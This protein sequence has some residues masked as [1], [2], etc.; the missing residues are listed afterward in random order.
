MKIKNIL[1]G[2]MLIGSIPKNVQ[3][4]QAQNNA[5]THIL[6]QNALLGTFKDKDWY[7]ENI[8]FLE[9]PDNNIQE[10]YYYRWSTYKLHLRYINAE[11]GYTVTEFADDPFWAAPYGGIS[12]PAGHQIYEGRWLKNQRFMDDFEIY[13]ATGP[14]HEQSRKYSFWMADAYYARY[15]VNGDNDFL[16]G[17][18]TPLVNNFNGWEDHYNTTFGM[19]W[20]IG[21]DDGMEFSASSYRTTDH[22]RGGPGYR[23]TI[24]AYQYGDAM[25]ISKIYQLMGNAVQANA[26]AKKADDLKSN[27]HSKLWDGDAK[28]FKHKY[29]D[30]IPGNGLF[31]DNKYFAAESFVDA[32]EEMGY[33]P[34]YFN[35]VN[36]EYTYSIS[37]DLLFDATKGFY[38]TFGPTTLEKSHP[39]YRYEDGS[40]CRWNG[41]SWP[42]A[43]SQTLVAMANVLNNYT[44]KG[45]LTNDKY[46]DILKKF[47]LTQYMD[48][49]PFIAEA[50]D[51]VTDVWT[52]NS[53]NHSEHYNHSTYTDLIITGLIGLRPRPDNVFEINPLIP[54]SW[55]YFVLENVPYH[56]HL[57]TIL[58][59]KIGT[60]Y[61]KEAGL[62]IYQDGK[63]LTNE[64]TIQKI[65]VDMEVANPSNT[66][67][68]TDRNNLAVNCDRVGY[69]SPTASFTSIYDNLWEAL[70]GKLYF[71]G[72][73]RSRWTS[74]GS[75]N[76]T[77][78][79]AVEF[80]E[81]KIINRIDILFYNDNGGVKTPESY[82]VQYWTGTEWSNI[83]NQLKNPVEPIDDRNTIT[84]SDFST[85]KVRVLM[86]PK[87]GASVGIV[88][89]EAS[90]YKSE[91]TSVS[92]QKVT[93]N[94]FSVSPCPVNH[95]LRISS[96][97]QN[98]K[99]AICND[100]GQLLANNIVQNYS[101]SIDFSSYE[102]GVY[103]IK[104]ES[105]DKTEVYKI[106][107]K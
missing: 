3:M 16:K 77:D 24:N 104:I 56:G 78:W 106:M 10:V 107:K 74:Y 102:D 26:F 98:F 82:Q 42:F 39:L 34:W 68:I 53:Q 6:D 41:M 94:I 17:M 44:N 100:F 7:I 36:D 86:S 38:S 22:I 81:P 4:I 105:K 76:E 103:I 18:I 59:D 73:P 29:R 69:P 57:M 84:F 80:N 92:Q 95:E 23:P 89:F 50:H 31:P 93:K 61:N 27:L 33:V 25:A 48:G 19:Y 9:V 90:L 62:T 66:F 28:F 30:A 91:T 14:G 43:T 67:G 79:Y 35:M 97:I 20:Q 40:C 2:A 1:I 64:P 46:F 21:H 5:S 83:P 11:K 13:W 87:P 96:G 101:T 45:G 65:T 12:C 72:F 54:D 85:K 58:Y 75:K 99:Y 15:L 8:P 63:L 60:K 52:Y 32:R 55:D 51:P 49:Q 37:W 71:D 70:D 47:A 88:E